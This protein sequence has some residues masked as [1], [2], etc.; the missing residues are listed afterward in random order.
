MAC[1]CTDVYFCICTYLEHST[2]WGIDI[3]DL[4]LPSNCVY[5]LY[6]CIVRIACICMYCLYLYYLSGAII[7]NTSPLEVSQTYICPVIACICHLGI[8][9]YLRDVIWCYPSLHPD[10]TL[11]PSYPPKPHLTITSHIL[12]CISYAHLLQLTSLI[13]A[14][15]K[16]TLYIQYI[17]TTSWNVL[18]KTRQA[19]SRKT[20]CA[21]LNIREWRRTPYNVGRHPTCCYRAY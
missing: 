5:F 4:H 20:K 10:T 8:P 3:T 9:S 12:Y 2:V 11:I 21:C 1:I 15:L 17:T 19:P 18:D 16:D 6:F 13:E 7:S 14:S